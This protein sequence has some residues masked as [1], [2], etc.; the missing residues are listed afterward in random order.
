MDIPSPSWSNNSIKSQWM[1][2]TTCTDAHIHTNIYPRLA[3]PVTSI[4]KVM[5]A[6]ISLLHISRR[7]C[8][9]RR[10]AD[11]PLLYSISTQQQHIQRTL[12]LSHSLPLSFSLYPPHPIIYPSNY[13]PSSLC[14]FTKRFSHIV[15]YF[16]FFFSSSI[17]MHTS[18]HPSIHTFIH[19]QSYS[20]PKYLYVLGQRTPMADHWCSIAKTSLY[21]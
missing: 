2:P 1:L 21:I 14:A 15:S 11:Y 5:C 19:I 6:R 12:Q 18:I 20:T 7:L 9:R 17:A 13:T 3:W 4:H 16:Y 10:R 8:V